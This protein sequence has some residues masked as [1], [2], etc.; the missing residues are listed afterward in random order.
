MVFAVLTDAFSPLVCSCCRASFCARPYEGECLWCLPGSRAGAL[1][2]CEPPFCSLVSLRSAVRPPCTVWRQTLLLLHLITWRSF[3]CVTGLETLPAERAEREDTCLTYVS[4]G[5]PP[6]SLPRFPLPPP[7]R[8]LHS[9]HATLRMPT[10]HAPSHV[11]AAR[12]CRY[13]GR[14]WVGHGLTCRLGLCCVS[15][16]RDKRGCTCVLFSVRLGHGNECSVLA[17]GGQSLHVTRRIVSRGDLCDACDGCWWRVIARTD[18][19]VRACFTDRIMTDE[20]EVS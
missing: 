14:Q 16:Q 20:L 11:F 10:L 12:V 1:P 2:C 17:V 4:V 13:D 18:S 6:L 5:R 9:S 15:T 8:L 3:A 7:L 19:C